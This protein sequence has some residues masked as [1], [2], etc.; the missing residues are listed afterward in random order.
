CHGLMFIG[1]VL[2]RWISGVGQPDFHVSKMSAIIFPTLRALA[3]YIKMI[4][5]TVSTN[6]LWMTYSLLNHLNMNTPRV[7]Y[8]GGKPVALLDNIS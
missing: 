7:Y 1:Y 6:V 8:M 4:L 5:P 2:L 3:Y